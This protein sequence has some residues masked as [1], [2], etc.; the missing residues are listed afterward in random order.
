MTTRLLSHLPH[1]Q[2]YPPA[3]PAQLA[4]WKEAPSASI[5]A[6]IIKGAFPKPSYG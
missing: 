2:H 6:A 5:A 4:N 1:V 3:A